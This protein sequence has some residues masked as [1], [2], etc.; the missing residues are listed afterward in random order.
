ML[1]QRLTWIAWPAF[2]VA[3]LLEAAV[4]GMVDPDDI[5]WFG[6]HMTLSRQGVYTVSF[7]VF[8]CLTMVSSSLTLLL[9]ISP[10]AVN[11]G[12]EL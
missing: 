6:Q 10:L 7:F 4:F 3:G 2:L 8:W 5:R 12:S 11:R 9:S 1:T